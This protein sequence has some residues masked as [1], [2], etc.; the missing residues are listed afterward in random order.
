MEIV[1]S[2][3]D[4]LA[5]FGMWHGAYAQSNRKSKLRARTTNAANLSGKNSKTGT[6]FYAFLDTFSFNLIVIVWPVSWSG[7]N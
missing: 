7:G 4:N 5:Q 1:N 2:D 3:E 6:S